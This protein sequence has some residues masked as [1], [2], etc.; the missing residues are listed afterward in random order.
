MFS[1]FSLVLLVIIS[2]LMVS[3]YGQYYCNNDNICDPYEKYWS[4]DDCQH[5]GPLPNQN[6]PL[7]NFQEPEP[8]VETTGM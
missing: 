4:C 5:L 7:Q 6:A 2:T 8:V 1:K 3:V